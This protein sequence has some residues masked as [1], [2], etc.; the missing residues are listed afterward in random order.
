MPCLKIQTNSRIEPDRRG[1]ILRTLSTGVA[2]AL[3][4]PESYVMVVLEP[5]LDMLFAGDDAPLAY[6]ELKS[7]GLPP[8]QT[9]ALSSRLCEL[10]TETIQVAPERVY[11]EFCGPERKNWGWNGGT[12]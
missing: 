6:L 5:N 12:F 9:G 10:M 11:I 8:D 1:Q 2:E 4:K 7:L 3:G